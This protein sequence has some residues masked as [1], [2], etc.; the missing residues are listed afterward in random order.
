M[1]NLPFWSCF[2]CFLLTFLLLFDLVCTVHDN[3][4]VFVRTIFLKLATTLDIIRCFV[5]NF[6][7]I[8][9]DPTAKN[10]IRKCDKAYTSSFCSSPF[11]FH[12]GSCSVKYWFTSQKHIHHLIEILDWYYQNQ[13]QVWWYIRYSTITV[14]L[15]KG[16]YG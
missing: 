3:H 8:W 1:V 6:S 2:W 4:D 12:H 11:I 16:S 7:K 10:G 14:L 13:L 5:F 15:T 9:L